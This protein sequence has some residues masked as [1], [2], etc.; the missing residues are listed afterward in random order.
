MRS[1]VLQVMELSWR[2]AQRSKILIGVGIAILVAATLA[3]VIR[4]QD[5][6]TPDAVFQ[7]FVLMALATVFVP[8]LALLVG[9]HAMASER[10]GGTLPF[11][12]TRPIPRAAVVLGK[13]ATAILVAVAASAVAVTLVYVAM[14]LPTGAQLGGA[15]AATATMAMALTAIFVLLGTVLQRSLYA[16]LAYIALYEGLLGNVV[17][18]RAG[19]SV[20]WHGR[21]LIS[22][23]AGEAL[24]FDLASLYTGSVAASV[25]TLALVTL[26]ALAGAALWADRREYGLREKVKEE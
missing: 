14:G 9:T 22:A 23:W 21:R 10:E 19:A 20:T 17:A 3:L 1:A 25:L 5:P 4:T 2:Q 12:F 7:A 24:P 6:S 26:A 8:L 13:G 16:G 18:G 11:L 15:I